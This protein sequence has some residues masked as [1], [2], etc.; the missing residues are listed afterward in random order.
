MAQQRD[1]SQPLLTTAQVVDLLW[2][3]VAKPG[4]ARRT[5]D[6]RI[7]KRLTYA[8]VK[9]ELVGSMTTKG[10]QGQR[11]AEA[12]IWPFA[13][14]AWPAQFKDVPLPQSAT[15]SDSAQLADLVMQHVIPGNLER[16]QQALREVLDLADRLLAELQE[17]KLR[18]TV[19]ER[20]AERNRKFRELSGGR[21]RKA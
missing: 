14:G 13:R 16:C 9:R 20:L 12:D 10:L 7:R 11:F 8:M 19:L 1:S 18:V 15:A 2:K 17:A 21:G 5:V 3:R 6:A 4:E